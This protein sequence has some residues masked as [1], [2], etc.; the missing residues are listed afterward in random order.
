MSR[1]R[2]SSSGWHKPV[3]TPQTGGALFRRWRVV[4]ID[5]STRDVA[6][7]RDDATEFGRPGTGAVGLGP[8]PGACRRPGASE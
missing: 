5:G 7:T 8:P 2:R 1:R 4:A 6:D 3:A